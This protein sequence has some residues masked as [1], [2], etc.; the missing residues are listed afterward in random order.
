MAREPVGKVVNASAQGLLVKARAK[1][2]IGTTLVDVRASPVG[3]VLDVLGP[4]A[5]PYL[6]V[7]IRKGA[8]VQRLLSREVYL[9]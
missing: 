1:V 6:L 3:R 4:V 8:N 5:S 9:P 7:G 2:S